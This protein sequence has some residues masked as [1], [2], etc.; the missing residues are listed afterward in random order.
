MVTKYKNNTMYKGAFGWMYEE[1]WN[2]AATS[3]IVFGW[4]SSMNEVNP[5][6]IF[7][8]TWSQKIKETV[9]S[10]THLTLISNQTHLKGHDDNIEKLPPRYRGENRYV[11]CGIWRAT[12]DAIQGSGRRCSRSYRPPTST[13]LL[14]NPLLEYTSVVYWYWIYP[15]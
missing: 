1:G 6:V 15:R 3:S 14:W 8:A 2:E 12:V 9:S 13:V 11:R 5:E 10:P 4:E 7:G